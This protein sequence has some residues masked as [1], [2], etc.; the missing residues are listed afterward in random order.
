MVTSFK[1]IAG[2]SNTIFRTTGG[3]FFCQYRRIVLGVVKSEGSLS[4]SLLFLF[5]SSY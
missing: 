3:P 1:K 4:K 2:A 5:L